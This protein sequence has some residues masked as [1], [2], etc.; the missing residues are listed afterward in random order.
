MNRLCIKVFNIKIYFD[1][2]FFFS[3]ILLT[4]LCAQFVLPYHYK[5]MSKVHCWMS[6][7]IAF[8]MFSFLIFSRETIRALYCKLMGFA[9]KK[10]TLFLFGS[11]QEIYEGNRRNLFSVLSGIFGFLFT[12]ATFIIMFLFNMYTEKSSLSADFKLSTK[13]VLLTNVYMGIV[14][15]LPIYTLDCGR[16]LKGILSAISR[17]ELWSRK[18]MVLSG[19]FFCML[20]ILLG[21]IMCF[22]GQV[23]G[24]I[25]ITVVGE[26]L[27]RSLFISSMNM[28]LNKTIAQLTLNRS[29]YKKDYSVL[30]NQSYETNSG[31]NIFYVE[32]KSNNTYCDRNSF[33]NEVL[34]KQENEI[35]SNKKYITMEEVICGNIPTLTADNNTEIVKL[36]Y[37]MLTTGERV[38]VVK[39]STDSDIRASLITMDKIAHYVL[40]RVFT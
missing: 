21:V 13:I 7:F 9:I 32:N 11:N 36:L 30:N 15:L 38:C 16:V 33:R 25:G 22:R 40:K 17:N 10:Y 19:N 37:L 1:N 5:Q 14:N 24:G 29:L 6:S 18:I 27:R 3:V 31:S 28:L 20:I 4:A 2:F 8:F 26:S 12:A 39:R 23:V 35:V 34:S